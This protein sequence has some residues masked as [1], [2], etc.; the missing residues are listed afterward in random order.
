MIGEL[1]HVQEHS[2][3]CGADRI[4]TITE[5]AVEVFEVVHG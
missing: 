1:E 3:W 2:A 4:E 5:R